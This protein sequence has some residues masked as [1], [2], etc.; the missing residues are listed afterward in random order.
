MAL[1]WPSTGRRMMR[2]LG[3]IKIILSALVLSIG[4]PVITSQEVYASGAVTKTLTVTT[5]AGTP[6]ANA[7]VDIA[8]LD[9]ST[10]LST[11]TE[12]ITN[13]SG[14][15]TFTVPKQQTFAQYYVEPAAGDTSHA[16]GQTGTDL[17]TNSSDSLILL[18]AN[19]KLDLQDA[20]NAATWAHH[21]FNFQGVPG[22]TASAWLLRSGPFGIYMNLNQSAG[23][24]P[25]GYATYNAGGNGGLNQLNAPADQFRWR[26]CFSFTGTSTAKVPNFFTDTTCTTPVPV[27]SEGV[28]VLQ[29]PGYNVVGHLKNPDGTPFSLPT[30]VYGTASFGPSSS[31]PYSTTTQEQLVQFGLQGTANV[32]SN[33]TFYARFLGN[34]AAKYQ[35]TV[36]FTGSSTLPKSL[37]FPIWKDSSGKLSTS[38]SGTYVDATPSS[39]LSF[40]AT[41]TTTGLNFKFNPVA[42]GTSTPI[43]G[44]WQLEGQ[45][46]EYIDSG[47]G[48][49]NLYLPDSTYTLDYTPDDSTYATE[50]FAIVVSASGSHVSVTNAT[51]GFSATDQ[52]TFNLPIETSNFSFSSV[53]PNELHPELMSNATF[54]SADICHLP[55]ASGVKPD[56]CLSASTTVSGINSYHLPD[57]LYR[58]FLQP[59]NP[60]VDAETQFG[61]TVSGGVVTVKTDSGSTVAKNSSLGIYVLP[62]STPN[63]NAQLIDPTTNLGADGASLTLLPTSSTYP[64]GH[65]PGYQFTVGANGLGSAYL[66]D[67]DYMASLSSMDGIEN[68]FHVHVASGISTITELV[69]KSGNNFLLPIGLPNFIFSMPGGNATG[70]YN[71]W[72]ELCAN[73]TITYRTNCVGNGLPNSLTGGAKLLPGTYLLI[74]HPNNDTLAAAPWTINV[75][76]NGTVTVPG[77]TQTLG[78]WILPGATPN[79]SFEVHNPVDNTLLPGG[80]INLGVEDSY[81]N[82]TGWYPNAD[83]NSSYPGL[84]QSKLPDGHYRVQL[85]SND[86]SLHFAMRSYELVMASGVPALTLGGNA[87]SKNGA[88]YIVSPATANFTFRLVDP[89]N[90]N[91]PITDGWLD[92]CQDLGFGQQKIGACNGT[93]VD[94]NGINYVNI[95]KGNWFVRVNPGSNEIASPKIYPVSVDNAGVVTSSVLSTPSAGNPWVV[96]AG[97]PNVSGRLL[98]S[99]GQP[100]VLAPNTNQGVQIQLQELDTYGNWNWL[101]IGSWRQSATYG[102]QVTAAS[103]VTGTGHF[104]ILAQP[105]N[106][107]NV[108]DSTST[109]FYLTSAGKIS[110]ISKTGSDAADSLPTFDIT[111]KSPNLNLEIKNPIDNSDLPGG[112]I[113][114]FKVDDTTKGQQLSWVGNANISNAGDGLASTYLADGTYQLQVNPQIGASM[115]TGLSQKLYKAVVTASGTSIV[116]TPWGSTQAITKTGSRFVLTAAAANITGRLMT[117][118]G[119][120]LIPANNQW[121]NINLQ[122][123]NLAKDGWD[124][125]QN[126]FNT[127]QNGN[128]AIAQSDPGTYR[129]LIQP[130]GYSTAATTYTQP[131]TI[132]S[133]NAATFKQDY[134]NLPLAKPDLIV[135]VLEPG[136]ATPIQ[137][138]SINVMQFNQWISN[139]WTG[140]GAVASITFPAAGE[141][142]LQLYP[143]STATQD[144]FTTKTYTATVTANSNGTKSVSFGTASGV[145]TGANGAVTLALGSANIRGTVTL[146]GSSTTVA[147]SQVVPYDTNGNGLWQYSV[148]TSQNGAW[149]MS[150]PTGTYTVQAQPAYGDATH[151]NS[152]RLGTITVG[153]DGVAQVSD[154]LSGVT[155]TTIAIPLRNPTWSGVIQA[156]GSSTTPVPYAQV[157]LVASGNNWSCNQANANGEWAFTAPSGFTAFDGSAQLQVQDVQGRLYANTF[158]QGAV[159]VSAALNGVPAGSS[160]N[161]GIIIHMLSPNLQITVL[162]GTQPAPYV[163]VNVIQASNYNWLGNAQTN[164]Q[165]VANFNITN[166]NQDLIAQVDLGGN[167]AFSSKYAYTVKPIPATTSVSESVTVDLAI[168]NIL[169]VVHAQSTGSTLGAT[170]PYEWVEL[171]SIDNQGNRNWIGS[172]GSD[173]NGRFA[174][175]APSSAGS[176]LAVVVHASQGGVTNGTDST[177]LVTMTGGAVSSMVLS[178]TSTAAPSQRINDLTYYDLSLSSPNVTG[179][180]KDSAGA[181]IQNSWIQPFDVTH[182]VWL[183]SP[184]SDY[185][186]NFGLSLPEGTYQLQANP[187]DYASNN[188]KSSICQVTVTGSTVSAASANCNTS[189]GNLSNVQLKLHAPNLTFTLVS[190]TTPIANANVNIGIGS[191]NTWANSDSSGHISLYIDAADIALLNP[192]MSGTQSLNM[193]LNPPYGQSDLMVQSYCYSGQAGTACQSLPQVTI[194]AAFN[195]GNVLALGNVAVKG[196]NTRL[197]IKTPTGTAVGPNYWI[198]LVSFDTATANNYRYLGG[199]STDA[200]GVAWFNIDTSTATSNTR[201]GVTIYPSGNDSGSYTTGYVGDYQQFGDWIH[202]LTWAQLTSPSTLLA[203]ASPN[204]SITVTSGDGVAPDRYGWISIMQLDSSG[205]AIR[206]WGSGL[207]Y[208]GSAS[209][210]L[211]GNTTY[212]ITAYPNGVSGAP[213]TCT[214]TTNTA[215]PV[216]IATVQGCTLAA[217]NALSLTLSLGNVHGTVVGPDGAPLSGAIVVAQIGSDTS[218][219]VSTSTAS[220]GAFGFN[221]DATKNYTITV[222]FPVGTSYPTKN[223]PFTPGTSSLADVNLGAIKPGS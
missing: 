194:G 20:T 108:A 202:G 185:N 204:A 159:A 211:S 49:A 36:S 78:R 103:D 155:P 180:V 123:Q 75:A 41:I 4:F 209:M 189:P 76:S 1:G 220:N 126:W 116:M 215:T 124:Y 88:R 17:F 72:Y 110:L 81:G 171:D 221:I 160:S 201:Y 114:F 40:N 11:W 33:G 2:K 77:A 122:T 59:S 61:V 136:L 153:L 112:W 179:V 51:S 146:P 216:G 29:S 134:G 15:V 71:E 186:G 52:S 139:S 182:R 44:T 46:Q 128:F 80:W 16:P 170:I 132:T 168:P 212:Q 217:G 174:F 196:P 167:P 67:G 53:G 148:G 70:S 39:P 163:N 177:Y 104:R 166:L 127:D 141:Y 23:A 21:I 90:S 198:N 54:S 143:D 181:T 32:A 195:S 5:E 205:R 117:S 156:P 106:L 223:V 34:I 84:T 30:G 130:N 86:Q 151:G 115:I 22:Q 27:T 164:S 102:L 95:E 208:S 207:N 218:T 7:I 6:L 8:Y 42:Q 58:I 60:P 197:Q 184:N 47:Y 129:L 35:I 113:T 85:Y 147:N 165:G 175:F 91:A 107:S 24:Y 187:P 193:W 63:F 83:F 94:S 38:Q 65:W 97:I 55:S 138:V 74:V 152:N 199:A 64:T 145:G 66:I 142:S 161:T 87:V 99:A 121:V 73:S 105:Q 172:T 12:R 14:Q 92:V 89:T 213:T 13:S 111:V 100:L 162:G 214:I 192:G 157:C 191:W 43:Y 190:G 45:K 219:T 79:V 18:N 101:G 183:N 96:P 10:S 82:V 56:F 173:M 98:D 140:P 210:L 137:N 62:N 176:K 144:G 37:V 118:D 131:F 149:S 19:V 222:I 26:G 68:T 206:G 48:L 135:Q 57:G 133:A 158:F 203:P 188:A 169:G 200:N 150:L 178:G 120:A 154:A 3:L 31:F 109:E 28:Y 93:G 125:S 50:R 25:T 119:S 9:L 69:V